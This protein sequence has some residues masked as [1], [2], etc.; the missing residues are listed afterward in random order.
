ME[1]EKINLQQVRDFGET[2]SVSVKLI[3]QNFKLFFQ[4]L[5][6]LAGPFVL[7]S[8]L[9]GAFYQSSALTMSSAMQMTNPMDVLGQ[10]GWAYVI[11]LI[12]TVIANLVMM[13]TVFAFMITYQEKG[14]GNFTVNDVGQKLI[15]NIGNII[16][17]FLIIF[18]ISVILIG[19]IAGIVVAIGIGVPALGI[20]LGLLILIGLLLVGP[21]IFWQLSVIYL[22]GMKENKNTF[23]SFAKTREVMKDNFWW[24]WVIVVCGSIAIGIIGFVFALP[25]A[26]YQM[27]LMFSN[28]GGQGDSETSIP[29]LIVATV[30]TFCATLVQ[31]LMHLLNGIHYYSLDEQ[32]NGQ[33]LMERINEIGNTSNSNVEQHY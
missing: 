19:I 5:L 15:Q 12:A 24:T 1:Q 32:K 18:I 9:A 4:C 33:G 20:L 13:G 30:C 29:F 28:M 10:F 16:L 25:Q 26:A 22:V 23:E 14:P 31:S 11:F 27:I 3:R 17:T 8:S 7:L 6:L 21:P 2:F